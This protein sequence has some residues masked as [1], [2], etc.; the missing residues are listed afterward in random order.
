MDY[1]LYLLISI[2]SIIFYIFINYSLSILGYRTFGL[3]NEES[4]SS[5]QSDEKPLEQT[6]TRLSYEAYIFAIF[7]RNL[8]ICIGLSSFILFLE[9]AGIFDNLMNIKLISL[10]ILYFFI[11]VLS[12][13]ITNKIFSVL[14][15]KLF[16]LASFVGKF[17]EFFSSVPKFNK[18]IRYIGLPT[19][20]ESNDDDKA[21]ATL[22]E[23]LDLLESDQIP[24]HQ[25]DLM[26][27]RGILRMDDLRV[28]EIMKPR[29]DIVAASI[30]EPINSI[31]EKMTV[32]GYS[33]IP[34]YNSDL[35]SIIGIL[36]ARDILALESEKIDKKTIN[37]L[38]RQPIY[39]PESQNLETLLKE[40]QTHNISIG[41]VLDEHGTVSGLV[42]VI[43]L[44][45]EII[46]ELSDEFDVDPPEIQEV[47]QGIFMLDATLSIDQ[48]NRKLNLKIDS[49]GIS[50][51]GGFI[52]SQLGRIPS[53]GDVVETSDSFITVRSVVG[54]RI[55]RVSLAIK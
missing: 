55:R 34:I 22:I 24:A 8:I 37:N 36:F 14:N 42:T 16:F 51:I 27:I 52:Y 1:F 54:R 45:E 7:I 23:T 44:I 47:R 49:E 15:N 21:T 39:I 40:F 17:L 20:N 35:D 48:I 18:F 19:S 4:E 53:N 43:D 38:I 41:I 9:Q 50:T 29:P 30:D 10:S 46:G 11:L 31:I 32:G 33:K 13:V 26:M 2:F 25:E 3:N 12:I 5:N 28:S 6:S